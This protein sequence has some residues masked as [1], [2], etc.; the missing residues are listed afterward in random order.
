MS[1][2]QGLRS[3]SVSHEHIAL[4]VEPSSDNMAEYNQ[5]ELLK[6]LLANS[7]EVKNS[8]DD[9]KTRVKKI[10]ES[11]D[12]MISRIDSVELKQKD[13]EQK[14]D[15]IIKSVEFNG[16][17]ILDLTNE[18]A[19]KKEI[20]YLKRE[21][22]ILKSQI[23]D[24]GNRSRRNNIVIHNLP[25]GYEDKFI[26]VSSAQSTTEAKPLNADAAPFVQGASQVA[27]PPDGGAAAAMPPADPDAIVATPPADGADTFAA[28]TKRQPMSRFIE[29]FLYKELGLNVEIDAAHR[30]NPKNPKN[31]NGQPRLI[32]ARV[33]RRDDRDR[34]L[35]AAPSKL[36]K[37]KVDGNS[38]FIT[39]D[40]DETTRYEHKKLLTVQ[41]D[42]R[43][44][45]NWFAYIPW[46]IPRVIKYKE[47]P[48]DAKLPLKTFRVSDIRN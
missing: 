14:S 45:N 23:I 16:A 8:V 30:T 38:I 11:M 5:T 34:I 19:D 22:S 42:M 44:K 40:V 36:R 33:L 9:I 17:K 13:L 7:N 26:D 29:H 31:S 1:R 47:G 3:S 18:K 43:E 21:V 6:Q 48:R 4:T 24:T 28:R 37:R 39:D 15:D 12:A 46:S 20:D 32:H 10:E 27:A 35:K 25:E 2:R 41:K